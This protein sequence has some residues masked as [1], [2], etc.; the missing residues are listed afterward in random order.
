MHDRSTL[1]ANRG[2]LTVRGGLVADTAEEDFR[3]ADIAI[4][5]HQVSQ[6]ALEGAETSELAL[7]ATGCH[8]VPGFVDVQ[9]NGGFGIDLTTEPQRVLELASQLGQF[10]VTAFCPTVITGPASTVPEGIRAVQEARG[11]S[12]GT[13]PTARILGLHAEG[14][15][16]APGRA[17]AHPIEHIRAPSRDEVLAWIEMAGPSRD[18]PALAMVTI[19]PELPEATEIIHLLV[20]AGVR[21]CAGHTEASARDI[22]DSEQHGVTGVTHLFNAMSPLGHR[23]PGAVGGTLSS[24]T[25]IAG[26]IAD[27]VHVDPVTVDIAWRIL[28]RERTALVTDSIAALGVGNGRFHLGGVTVDVVGDAARNPDRALAGS[29]LTMDQAVRN[30]IAYTGCS[31]YDA[32]HAASTTPLRLVGATATRSG[33]HEGRPADLV[34]L[35]ESLEVVATVIDGTVV[36][37]PQLR[38]S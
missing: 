36:H 29:M 30:L 9:V 14:P 32:C 26:L 13:V 17:G 15:Y 33:I 20:G 21:V 25:L 16:I 38:L 34:L 2:N 37:D 8:V 11:S 28:G 23:D 10:G 3:R 5:A 4:R 7:D 27:G 1:R 6:V 12:V 31:L 24:R 19:A 22:E 35:D 18:H